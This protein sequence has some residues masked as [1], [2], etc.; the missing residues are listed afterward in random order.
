MVT[1][2]DKDP[3]SW[4]MIFFIGGIAPLIA[5]PLLYW[6]LPD[7]RQLHADPHA[8]KPPVTQALF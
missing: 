1:F 6:L 4:R 5:I 3:T 2:L 8:A 7:S